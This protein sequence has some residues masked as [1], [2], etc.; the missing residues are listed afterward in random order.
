MKNTEKTQEE[1]ITQ[2]KRKPGGDERKNGAN[3]VSKG[4]MVTALLQ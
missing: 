3:T 4:I 2:C 1:S